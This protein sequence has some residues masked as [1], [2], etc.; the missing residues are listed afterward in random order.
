MKLFTILRIEL[1]RLFR[2]R[3]TYAGYIMLASL[4]GLVTWGVW[5]RSPQAVV[6]LEG[7]FGGDF[8]VGGK[9]LSA[10]T[11]PYYLLELPST[12]SF[13]LPLLISM[14]AGG[15]IAGEAQTG[16]LRTVLTRPVHRWAVLAGKLAAALIHAISLVVWLGGLSLLVGY[17][18]FGHGDLVAIR[19]GFRVFTEQEGLARLGMAYAAVALMMCSVAAIALLCST[20]FEHALTASGVTVGFLILSAVLMV[21]PFFEWLAPYLLTKHFHCYRQMFA[22]TIDWEAT[23]IDMHYTAIYAIV[24]VAGALVV[25]CRKDM[26][27]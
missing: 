27:C 19:G 1:T 5:A 2:Q 21:I 22:N 10:L 6:N 17:I 24:A 11:V 8:V 4:I 14:V 20:I 12:V 3:G 16:T 23:R 25:F 9:V 13:F 15:I 18:V 26:T 7:D